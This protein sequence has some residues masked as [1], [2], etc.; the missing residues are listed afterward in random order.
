MKLTKEQTK[1]LPDWMQ[2]WPCSDELGNYQLTKEEWTRLV[3]QHLQ[4][5]LPGKEARQPHASVTE[6]LL[7]EI[8]ANYSLAVQHIADKVVG[9]R[10]AQHAA[11]VQAMLAK[12]QQ[13][14][15]ARIANASKARMAQAAKQGHIG[16]KASVRL[17]VSNPNGDS[18][19]CM[20]WDAAARIVPGQTAKGLSVRMAQ[21]IRRT[22]R[23]IAI[24]GRKKRAD[25]M[26]SVEKLA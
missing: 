9:D 24:I 5:P 8:L 2:S 25:Q 19:E 23:P 15:L 4:L 10:I 16:S 20:G 22:G 6:H 1:A 14:N 17:K 12:V 11:V 26:W 18:V 3:C 21:A 13:A 7:N